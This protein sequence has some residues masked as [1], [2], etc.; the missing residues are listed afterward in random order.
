MLGDKKYIPIKVT[1][2]DIITSKDQFWTLFQSHLLAIFG[3][4]GTVTDTENTLPTRAGRSLDFKVSLSPKLVALSNFDRLDASSKDLHN[5]ITTE[6]SQF[7][8]R[9]R[10]STL[11]IKH[12][13]KVGGSGLNKGAISRA[14]QSASDAAQNALWKQLDKIQGTS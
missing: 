4:I 14:V 1:N 6:C 10:F 11:F 9:Y 5:F 12:I 3:A 8:G 7:F 13:L 2:L